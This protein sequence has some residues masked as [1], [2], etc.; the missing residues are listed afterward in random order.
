VFTDHHTMPK[1]TQHSPHDSNATAT[2]GGAKPAGQA[3]TALTIDASQPLSPAQKRFNNL[4]ADIETLAT[5][6]DNLHRIIDAH[7]IVSISTLTPLEQEKA[8]LMRQ[9]VVW[10]NQRLQCKGLT[11]R[12]RLAARDVLR[13]MAA[14]LAYNGD[15]AMRKLH[16][17]HSRH[18]LEAFEKDEAQQA[19]PAKPEKAPRQIKEQAQAQD[20][21]GALRSIYRQLASALHPDRET[22]PAEQLRKT[23]LMKEANAAYERHDLLALL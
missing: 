12:Q 10:L 20:A 2:P 15:E 18:S 9:M 6:I 19:H 17:A 8:G 7:R 1:K 4:L 5:R 16:D 13:H 3:L 11:N 21:N 23:A 14:E 22:D